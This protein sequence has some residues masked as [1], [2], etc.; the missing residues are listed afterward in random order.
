MRVPC[1]VY[2]HLHQ[3]HFALTSQSFLYDKKAINLPPTS[4]TVIYLFQRRRV[5][6]SRRA[7]HLYCSER[8]N[9]QYAISISSMPFQ[10][11]YPN[12]NL[13][14]P[15]TNVTYSACSFKDT[16]RAEFVQSQPTAHVNLARDVIRSNRADCG[17]RTA[18]CTGR[19]AWR[20]D[21]ASVWQCPPGLHWYRLQAAYLMQWVK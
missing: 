1:T 6:L 17:L 18:D 4:T 21:S 19:V 14:G 5:W 9:M 20:T 12:R 13:N 2:I 16:R 10:N 7:Q 8:C 15:R 11:Q 3:L